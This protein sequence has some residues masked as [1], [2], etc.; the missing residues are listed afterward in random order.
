[1]RKHVVNWLYTIAN[2]ICLLADQLSPEDDSVW[3][4]RQQERLV[5]DRGFMEELSDEEAEDEVFEGFGP[6]LKW[7]D[8]NDR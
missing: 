1:M 7:G 2:A 6:V 8:D 5:N 4:E 3:R